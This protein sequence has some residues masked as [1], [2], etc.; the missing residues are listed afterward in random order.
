MSQK[1]ELEVIKRLEGIANEFK[2]RHPNLGLENKTALKSK[3]FYL[4]NLI[5]AYEKYEKSKKKES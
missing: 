2:R 5:D 3:A 4:M 1:Q